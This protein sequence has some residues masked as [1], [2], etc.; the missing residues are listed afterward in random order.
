MRDIF[1]RVVLSGKVYE[2]NTAESVTG[3]LQDTI[4]IYLLYDKLM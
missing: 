4:S 2:V 3:V 1:V